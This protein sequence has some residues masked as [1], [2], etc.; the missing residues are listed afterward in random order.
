LAPKPTSIRAGQR[1]VLTIREVDAEARFGSFLEQYREP[2]VAAIES[3]T[4]FTRREI[5]PLLSS[6]L[7]G[8]SEM[9]ALLAINDALSSGEFHCIVVDTAPFGHTLRLFQLPESFRKLLRFLQ[10]A[11]GRDA[12]LAAHFAGRA[13]APNPLI[14]EWQSL[15]EALLV[16]LRV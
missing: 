9:A 1:A 15:L 10:I 3:G 12:M 14:A 5:E 6:T 13:P 7:P 11:S 4:V 2:L 16:G 8:M